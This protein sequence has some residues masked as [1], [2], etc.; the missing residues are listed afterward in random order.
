MTNPLFRE[1]AITLVATAVREYEEAAHIQH[2]GLRGRMREMALCHLI[3]PLLP[4]TFEVGTGKVMDS[5]GFQSPQVDLVIYSRS[6]LPP[7][8]YSEEEGIFPCEAA[9]Y[10]IE[11]KTRATSR[12]LDDAIR[13]ARKLRK[14]VYTPGR[15]DSKGKAVSECASRVI[16]VFFA[17]S[18]DL[19]EGRS[20]LDRYRNRDDE[21]ESYPCLSAICVVGRG[22][23]FRRTDGQWVSQSATPNKDEVIDFVSGVANTLPDLLRKRGRP[24]L[25]SYLVEE[26]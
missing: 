6:I 22:Y 2:H 11:V 25:G 1:K 9:F 8:M 7:V 26:R 17:F 10:A 15:F 12:G 14:L 13:K 24:R 20:E 19:R 18:S 16:P 3:K 23:W 4:A 5:R 21:M